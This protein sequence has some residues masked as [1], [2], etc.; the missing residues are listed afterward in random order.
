MTTDALT[1]SS[2]ASERKHTL[3][4][5][6]AALTTVVIWALWIVG[7]RH[8]VTT[9]LDPAAVG[10]LRFAVPALVLAPVWWR[11]G[12]L[13]RNMPAWRMLGLLGSG[14]PFFLVVAT[15]AQYAPAAEIGPLL[16][17]TMPLFVALIAVTVFNERM[18][19]WRALGFGLILAG[20][21]AIAG[22]GLL[23]LSSGAWRGHLLFLLGAFMWAMY[24]HVF[25]RSGMTALEAA[26]LISMWS[27]LMLLPV[28]GASLFAAF[29]RGLAAPVF[30]QIVLQGVLSGVVGV[31]L[32]SVSVQRLGAARA[33]AFAPLGP[34]MAMLIAVPALGEIPDLAA[35]LGIGAT[36]VGVLLASGV[37]L[38][39]ASRPS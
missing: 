39:I 37:R 29:E 5:V 6:A 15:G 20:I 21:I 13:P 22:R 18:D 23:D 9:T 35:L 36:T 32:Y 16:P 4:G 19:R 11:A 10:I 3:V 33:A 26:A 17:G 34:V 1:A 28:G 30:M 14:A 7:T 12:L 25:R 24:T 2:A 8:A 27:V 38:P 31:I